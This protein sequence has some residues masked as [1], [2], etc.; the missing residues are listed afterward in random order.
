MGML[1]PDL[2]AQRSPGAGVTDAEAYAVAAIRW[3][4]AGIGTVIRQNPLRTARDQ[5]GR[6]A[7]PSLPPIRSAGRTSKARISEPDTA[8]DSGKPFLFGPKTRPTTS[9]GVN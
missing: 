2:C 4:D 1:A 3:V 5:H 9:V 7:H 8:M 6:R